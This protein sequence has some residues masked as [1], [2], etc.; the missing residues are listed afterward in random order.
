M[1][2]DADSVYSMDLPIFQENDTLF[3][4]IPYIPKDFE[5]SSNSIWLDSDPESLRWE[6]QRR[7]AQIQ[8]LFLMHDYWVNGIGVPILK[9]PWSDAEYPSLVKVWGIDHFDEDSAFYLDQVWLARWDPDKPQQWFV[10]A[11]TTDDSPFS[12]TQRDDGVWVEE[13]TRDY[14][15]EM[16]S[17]ML[18]SSDRYTQQLSTTLTQ[19][20]TTYQ[21]RYRHLHSAYAPHTRELRI[22]AYYDFPIYPTTD[23]YS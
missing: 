13:G 1:S 21:L 2:E 17:Q 22:E 16:L 15:N 20:L 5:L 14:L 12:T 19:A 23:C 3:Q 9:F 18:A 11:A 8:A 4:P 6:Y 10:I 7:T